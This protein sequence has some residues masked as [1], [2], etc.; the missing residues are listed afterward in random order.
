MS[1]RIPSFLHHS[2]LE[3]KGDVRPREGQSGGPD[4]PC[5]GL[6]DKGEPS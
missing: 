3:I 4:V 5:D 2:F 1:R 6:T